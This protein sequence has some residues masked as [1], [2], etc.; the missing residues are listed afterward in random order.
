[1]DFT[2]QEILMKIIELNWVSQSAKEAELIISDGIHKCL[3]FSQPCH[4]ELNQNF[5]EP[6]HAVDVEELKKIDNENEEEKISRSEVGYFSHS[7]VARIQNL[8]DA[9]VSIGGILIRL[10]VPIPGWATENDLVGFQCGR[11]DIW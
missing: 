11:L 5:N 4:M 8:H 3:A 10:D 7:C 1:M 9:V 2:I 6:L